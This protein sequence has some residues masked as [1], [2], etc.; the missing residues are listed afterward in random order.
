MFGIREEIIFISIY[1]R[2]KLYKRDYAYFRT[3]YGYTKEFVESEYLEFY[4]SL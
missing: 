2:I 3:Q 4:D 1:K